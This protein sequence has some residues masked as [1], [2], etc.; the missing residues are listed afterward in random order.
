MFSGQSHL[1]TGMSAENGETKIAKKITK[2]K[3]EVKKI[4]ED[5]DEQKSHPRIK[6]GLECR[7]KFSILVASNLVPC[8]LS[9]F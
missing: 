3:K 8:V 2:A 6:V 5:E 4:E 7:K 1:S 9:A